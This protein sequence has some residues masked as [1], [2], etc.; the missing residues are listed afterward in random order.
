MPEPWFAARVASRR[1]AACL[2]DEPA[3]PVRGDER[4]LA[5]FILPSFQRPRAWTE[6]QSVRLIESLWD[7][8]PIGVYVVNRPERYGSECRDWLLDGQQRWTAIT[9]YVAGDF[10]V[11]GVHYPD[12]SRIDRNRFRN[13][14]IGEAETRLTDPADCLRVYERLAYGGTPHDPAMAPGM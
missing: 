11:Y 5:G 2:E 10:P 14:T 1:I 9:S 8:L 12:L 4:R 7:G 13:T 3:R 6:E